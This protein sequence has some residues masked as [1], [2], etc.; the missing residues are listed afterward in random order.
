VSR[1]RSFLDRYRR[2][3]RAR[4]AATPVP[5]PVTGMCAVLAER[6]LVLLNAL[7]TDLELAQAREDDPD[8][9]A[10]LY[11]LDHLATRLRRNAENVR[12]LVG[13]DAA[14][15]A[16]EPVALVDVV[17]AALSS[18]ERY[19]RVRVGPVPP[20]GIA[21]AAADD[22]G[23]LLAEL[24]DN[25]AACSPPESEVLVTAQVT[26][27][28]GVVL[29]VQDAGAG[30]PPDR[31]AALNERISAAPAGER[32]EHTG[33][34]VVRRLAHEHDL[35]V[36]LARRVPHGTTASVLL[37]ATLVTAAPPASFARSAPEPADDDAAGTPAAPVPTTASGLP[38]R[39]SRVPRAPTT[40]A[41]P[42]AEPTAGPAEHAEF[43][44]DLDAFSEGEAA[45]RDETS[46]KDDP[47][48]D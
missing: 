32:A 24:L 20:R 8:A 29:R 23:R 12:V 15:P 34:A 5:D 26:G 39:V 16:D 47:S 31:T 1:A 28:G 11:R 43:L 10:V 25:A 18:I 17:R 30:L 19:Q 44:A 35:R 27:T 6:D 7:L 4:G 45:A 41:E 37:P 46:T 2:P 13:T 42:T 36:W 9:L 14:R 48:D 21:G 22:V 38:R 33:L 3:D 40:T